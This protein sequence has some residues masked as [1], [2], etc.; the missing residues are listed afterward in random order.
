MEQ[1]WRKAGIM[2]LQAAPALLTFFLA[3]L[4]LF[5]E[6][7][8]LPGQWMPQWTL[9]TIYFCGLFRRG[10]FPPWLAFLTG[11]MQDALTGLPLGVTPLAFLAFLIAVNRRRI[12]LAHEGFAR[13]WG[14]FALLALG[15]LLL[16]WLALSLCRMEPLPFAGGMSQWLST[17]CMYPL[18]H[19]ILSRWLLLTASLHGKE[20]VSRNYARRSHH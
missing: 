12:A 8:T 17:V 2:A 4:S 19:A 9:I 10:A 18:M 5:P 13:L 7:L 6:R 1:L 20:R 11:L 15:A 3:V 16:L 14:W